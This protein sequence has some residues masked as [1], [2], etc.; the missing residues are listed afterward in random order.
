MILKFAFHTQIGFSPREILK[1]SSFFDTQTD[2]DIHIGFLG[3]TKKF[4]FQDTRS[5]LPSYLLD[6]SFQLGFS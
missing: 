2:T 3:P 6:R 1:N 5:N 4:G